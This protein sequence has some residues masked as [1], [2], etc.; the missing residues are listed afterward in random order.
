MD[1]FYKLFNYVPGIILGGKGRRKLRLTI[2]PPSVSRL[3]R[4]CGSLDVSQPY[5]HPRS[6]TGI[7]LL[8]PS[9]IEITLRRVI[10]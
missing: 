6:V 9:H 2:L 10:R 3:P 8:L 1:I 4:R 7:A 5:R